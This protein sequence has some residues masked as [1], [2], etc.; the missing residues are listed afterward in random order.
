MKTIVF[1]KPTKSSLKIMRMNIINKV[2]KNHIS[3]VEN[4]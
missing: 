2:E 4:I 3:V 1:H